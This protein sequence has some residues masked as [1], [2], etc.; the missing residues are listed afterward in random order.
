METQILETGTD[1]WKDSDIA[2]WLGYTTRYLRSV[3]GRHRRELERHGPVNVA[4]DGTEDVCYWLTF[5]HICA[6]CMLS[7]T[8]TPRVRQILAWMNSEIKAAIEG[9]RD[10]VPGGIAIRREL[11]AALGFLFGL[12]DP[13]NK[14][15]VQRIT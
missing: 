15:T 13:R 7:R 3:V 2:A 6:V 10:H 12:S 1:R 4:P 9:K 8:K 14:K 11:E 5:E